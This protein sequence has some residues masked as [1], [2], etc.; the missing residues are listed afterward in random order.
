MLR[1]LDRHAV[2]RSAGSRCGI[3]SDEAILDFYATVETGHRV[4]DSSGAAH[5]I[6]IVMVAGP[7]V[8]TQFPNAKMA[9]RVVA[10]AAPE[11]S[12]PESRE[13]GPQDLIVRPDR[14]LAEVRDAG[15]R[16]VVVMK[17]TVRVEAGAYF[18]D[19]LVTR[20]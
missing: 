14:Q 11:A 10:L 12:P 9:V 8:S 15:G 17:T 19:A 20:G 7:F 6:R 2:R 3:E 1:H 13:P 4:V 5:A 18:V 16:V